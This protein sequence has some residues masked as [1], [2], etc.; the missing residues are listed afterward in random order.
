MNEKLLKMARQEDAL[1]KL[2]IQMD[3]CSFLTCSEKGF[4][5]WT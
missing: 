1:K 2:K 3:S 5:F 4:V